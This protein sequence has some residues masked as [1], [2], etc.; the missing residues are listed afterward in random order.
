MM[1]SNHFFSVV[2][3]YC[4]LLLMGTALKLLHKKTRCRNCCLEICVCHERFQHDLLVYSF[5]DPSVTVDGAAS[6]S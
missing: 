3:G 6:E 1:H 5:S 4:P 2:N